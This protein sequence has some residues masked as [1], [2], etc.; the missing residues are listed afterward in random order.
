MRRNLRL[1][2]KADSTL[3]AAIARMLAKLC[4]LTLT[5]GA[6]S[7]SGRTQQ[8]TQP[9]VEKMSLEQLMNVEVDAVYGA[10]K[11]KQKVTDAPSYVTIVSSE[12]IGRHGYKTLADVLQNVPGFYVT[13]R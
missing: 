5:G 10:S 13:R 4:A 9:D 3:C 8:S 2:T 1:G 7:A 12:E 6:L 11:F